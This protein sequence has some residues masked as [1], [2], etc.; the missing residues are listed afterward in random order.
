MTN[1]AGFG[2]VGFDGHME[3]EMLFQGLQEA[4]GGFFRE[5]LILESSRFTE[6][7][8]H[9][10]FPVLPIVNILQCYGNLS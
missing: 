6:E 4:I 5:L 10:P 7:C 1:A 9:T 2:S 3:R 8:L